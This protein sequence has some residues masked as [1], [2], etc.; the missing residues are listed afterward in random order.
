LPA[1]HTINL[2]KS[3]ADTSSFS[4][5]DIVELM[6]TESLLATGSIQK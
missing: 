6:M 2:L 5:D 4:V 1:V 3:I